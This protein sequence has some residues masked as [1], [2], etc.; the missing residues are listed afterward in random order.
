[1]LFRQS[2]FWDT[3]PKNIK[4]KKHANYV[5]ERILELGNDSEVRWLFQ[6]YRPAKIRQVAKSSRVLSPKTKNLWL[7]LLKK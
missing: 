7:L 2:L 3:D 4:I 5:I 1:M 6:T